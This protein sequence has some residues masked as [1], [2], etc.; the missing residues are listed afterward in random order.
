VTRSRGRIASWLTGVNVAAD[1]DHSSRQEGDYLL[2]ET[3]VA[4]LSR[5]I[6][7]QR[8]LVAGPFEVLG[9][10]IE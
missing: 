4:T 7:D 1:V 5:R 2:E 6:N 3:G 10:G 8:R 9:D